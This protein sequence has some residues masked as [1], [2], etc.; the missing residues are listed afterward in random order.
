MELQLLT[1]EVW[2]TITRLAKKTKVGDVAVAYLGTG[3]HERLPLR[4]G[5]TLVVD[6]GD[7]RVKCGMTDPSEIGYYIDR[8][9]DVFHSGGLHAKVFV[10]DGVAIVGSANVSQHS[11]SKLD[12]AAI[13][14]DNR[15]IVAES[16]A[17]VHDL[18][19][20]RVTRGHLERLKAIYRPPKGGGGLGKGRPKGAGRHSPLWVT[21]THPLDSLPPDEQE[22][23]D[24]GAARA[25]QSL[26]DPKGHEVG[27]TRWSGDS[28]FVRHVAKGDQVIQI[29]DTGEGVE[30]WPPCGVL[31]VGRKYT[32]RRG[33]QRLLRR[34]VYIEQPVHLETMSWQEF[35][36]AAQKADIAYLRPG[37]VR[38]IDNPD[39]AQAL[40]R[41]L[42]R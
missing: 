14:T 18:A 31:H 40:R 5:S 28:R 11:E 24:R 32:V 13:L 42:P 29:H 30:V 10:L 37:S 7:G 3:A 9:V 21:S 1:D 25:E 27:W 17:Y 41:I 33:E 15:G 4:R 8:G 6:A 16:R 39:D 36:E 20:Q 22:R 23:A 35:E 26:V 34:F 2:P 38:A 19:L 12:E